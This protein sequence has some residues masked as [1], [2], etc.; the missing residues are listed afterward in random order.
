MKAA[1]DVNNAYQ[2]QFEERISADIY[3]GINSAKK[4]VA[5]VLRDRD[6]TRVLFVSKMKEMA[7]MYKTFLTEMKLNIL[8]LEARILFGRVIFELAKL[9]QSFS[10]EL[11]PEEDSTIQNFLRSIKKLLTS[12]ND[13]KLFQ[14]Q[15]INSNAGRNANITQPRSESLILFDEISSVIKSNDTLDHLLNNVPKAPKPDGNREEYQRELS[16][17]WEEQVKVEEAVR[18]NEA[19]HAEEQRRQQLVKRVEEQR[20]KEEQKKQIEER[21]KEERRIMEQQKKR[22]EL[23]RKQ[24]QQ[25]I[26]EERLQIEDQKRKLIEQQQRLE[27]ERKLIEQEQKKLLV[28]QNKMKEEKNQ[29]MMEIKK[30]KQQEQEE[31]RIMLEK[32][33]RRLEEEQRLEQ[34]RKKDETAKAESDE[35]KESSQMQYQRI[36][37]RLSNLKQQEINGIYDD[38]DVPPPPP[39][40]EPQ[41]ALAKSS[42]SEDI[43]ALAKQKILFENK[44]ELEMKRLDLEFRQNKLNEQGQIPP[45]DRTRSATARSLK[46]EKP[47][48]MSLSRDVTVPATVGKNVG[49]NWSRASPSGIYEDETASYIARERAA[50]N[51]DSSELFPVIDKNVIINQRK[52]T[53]LPFTP[54]KN[55]SEPNFFLLSSKDKKDQKKNKKIKKETEKSPVQVISAPYAV[56]HAVH[57]DYKLEGLPAEWQAILKMSGI[58][59]EE[60]AR[61]AD[62]LEKVLK[63]VTTK[64]LNIPKVIPFPEEELIKLDDLLNKQDP[65][66]LYDKIKK[67][68]E[69][70]V[71]EVFEAIDR[72]TK[73]KIAIKK[74]NLDSDNGILTEESLLYE[75]YIMKKCKHENIVDFL[76]AYKTGRTIWV[77]M[78]FM[79]MGSVTDIL[80]QFGNL[81]MTETQIAAVCLGTLKGLVC[82]HSGHKIH[83]DIKSDNILL[84]D[85]GLVKIADF[86]FAAQLTTKKQ[87]R[88]TVVGTPYWMAPE[89]IQGL[90]YDAKVDIW[91]L[92]IMA[93]ECME[94]EPPYMDYPPLRALFMITTTGVP[95][96]KEPTKWST[97]IKHFLN[98]CLQR[99]P[100]SRPSATELLQHPFILSACSNTELVKLAQSSRHLKNS[101][102]MN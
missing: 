77:A 79:G 85:A 28:E 57:V 24:E 31:E 64:G 54:E 44:K 71:A 15:L 22:D 2:N 67:I 6:E 26:D 40:E 36:S 58:L 16:K 49:V 69:G 5:V 20:V 29:K 12:L 7:N 39:E 88:K 34:Q 63:R 47:L 19:K 10:G 65:T 43:D 48:T 100:T 97:H 37:S 99:E 21:L 60:A 92:G 18:L 81:P 95:E 62:A 50:G 25:K 14:T 4:V 1:M 27:E 41:N 73:K 23:L 86:G 90:D 33:L 3:E 102:S 52:H 101:F 61:N 87:K 45:V 91:S 75:I 11:S 83:R 59:P 94:G 32:E 56:S 42:S 84:N 80:D 46:L 89:L 13:L 51:L 55:S 98:I 76:D 78:E 66:K 17:R 93:M 68:G 72:K 82:I 53:N 35:D 38:D 8:Q 30:K 70:G 9:V 74:M 96:L